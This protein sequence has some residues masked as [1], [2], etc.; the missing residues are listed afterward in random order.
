M[1]LMQLFAGKEWRCRY[2][3]SFETQLSY[4]RQRRVSGKGKKLRGFI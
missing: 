4:E 3:M 1:V 2:K